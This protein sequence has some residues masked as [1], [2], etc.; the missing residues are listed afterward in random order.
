MTYAMA[1]MGYA[2]RVGHDND[3]RVFTVLI[4]GI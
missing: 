3:D 1:Q 2:A 4:A